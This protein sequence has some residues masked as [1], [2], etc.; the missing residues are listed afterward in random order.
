MADT[1]ENILYLG[2]IESVLF[3]LRITYVDRSKDVVDMM[4]GDVYNL[5]IRETMIQQDYV[6]VVYNLSCTDG[7]LY[8]VCVEHISFKTIVFPDGSLND[9]FMRLMHTLRP[10][11]EL[12]LVIEAVFVADAKSPTYYNLY[13][14]PDTNI[15]AIS[16]PATTPEFGPISHVVSIKPITYL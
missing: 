15:N 9:T 5:L 2:K 8:V 11:N 16:I 6:V 7:S 13:E 4:C 3:F 12:K 10:K 1:T 14:I